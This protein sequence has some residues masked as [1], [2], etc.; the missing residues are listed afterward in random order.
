LTRLC[1]FQKHISQ[2]D[3]NILKLRISSVLFVDLRLE[4][5]KDDRRDVRRPVYK[6]MLWRREV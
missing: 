6:P 2:A 3:Q 5:I 4:S 1:T